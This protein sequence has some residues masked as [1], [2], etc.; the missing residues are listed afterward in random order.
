MSGI[1]PGL[2][3]WSC[4]KSVVPL[5]VPEFVIT[6]ANSRFQSMIDC[7]LA[8]TSS[9]IKPGAFSLRLADR[10]LRSSVLI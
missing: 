1:D 9:K 5:S 8:K 2:L 6:R 10:D 3:H 7:S 4:T